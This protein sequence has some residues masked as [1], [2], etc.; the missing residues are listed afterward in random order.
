VNRRLLRA[1]TLSLLLAVL[2]LSAQMI[3]TI[4]GNGLL[5]AGADGVPATS[6]PLSLSEGT[7]GG[8]VFDRDGNVY[9]SESGVHRVRRIE[10][11]TGLLT[12]V[13]GT[14]QPGFSGDG[15]PATSAKLR[16]P[17]DLAFDKAGNLHISDLGNNRIRR[18]DRKS[19]VIE[20]FAGTG[21][22]IFTKDGSGARETP[23]GRHSGIV[24]DTAGN[25][26]VVDNY[27]GRILRIDA[28]TGLVSTVVGNGTTAL[29]PDAKTGTETGLPVPSSVRITSKGEVVFSVTGYNMVMKVK[30][31]TGELHR[32]AGTG[33]PG[34]SGDG[35]PALKARLSQPTAIAIDRDDDIWFADW[36]NNAVRRIDAKTGV[37][38]TRVGSGRPDRWGEMQTAGFAGDGGPADKAQLWR[39]TAL[40]FDPDGNLLIVDARNHRIRKVEKAAR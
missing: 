24:F 17:G 18:V 9:F 29:R 8:I 4:A 20:T 6:S 3:S 35:G 36:D 31:A 27:A 39:P 2:P 30:P 26:L 33:I 19:G 7:P 21:R 12:T 28:K 1:A 23:I 40:G 14:G 10:R 15:G 38:D 13:A 16:E 5:A 34:Y 32:V 11:K 37:I 22:P 25:L